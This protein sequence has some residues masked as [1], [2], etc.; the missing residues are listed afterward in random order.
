MIDFSV[1]VGLSLCFNLSTKHN[2][3]FNGG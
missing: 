1:W 2:G 3:K